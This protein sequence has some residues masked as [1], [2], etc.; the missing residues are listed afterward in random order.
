MTY[1]EV[2]TQRMLQDGW[3]VVSLS[4]EN[5]VLRK[6]K[7]INGLVAIL[8]LI[9]LLFYLIPGLLILLLGY[10]ARGE[11][12]IV[13]TSTQAENIEV[14][15]DK[16]RAEEATRRAERKSMTLR[17]RVVAL[18]LIDKIVGFVVIGFVVLVVVAAL[19]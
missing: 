17:E 5:V 11:E 15:R 6:K 19:T 3:T 13:V 12:T 8:G 9:G 18:T 1:L 10:V 7:S 14:A 4:A 16:K 2:Y